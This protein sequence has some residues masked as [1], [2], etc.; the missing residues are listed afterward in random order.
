[1]FGRKQSA[2]ILKNR[3]SKN[4]GSDEPG[5]QGLI[6]G[7]APQGLVDLG[8]QP[9]VPEPPQARRPDPASYMTERNSALMEA[10]SVPPQQ[11]KQARVPVAPPTPTPAPAATPAAEPTPA[12]VA[13]KGRA[14]TR[15][16][17]ADT[18]DV[19]PKPDAIADQKPQQV[20]SPATFQAA[21]W[22]VIVDGPGRGHSMPLRTGVSQLGRD[23]SQSI[24]LDFG[25]NSISRENHASIAFDI[26]QRAFFIGHGGK[27]NL[28]RLNDAPV[29]TTEQLRHGDKIR[30][31]E[32]TLQLIAF[33]GEHFTWSDP[34]EVVAKTPAP[35]TAPA[36]EVA[37]LQLKVAPATQD[38]RPAQGQTPGPVPVKP[39][40]IAEPS[41]NSAPVNADEMEFRKIAGKPL[42]D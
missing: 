34:S 22:L 29:L 8:Q 26:E 21:G 12:P 31:G 39:A 32:T 27:A 11:P 14:K 6:A 18:N 2:F 10:N 41:G 9:V 4:S 5:A 35:M 33:C 37:P 3:K 25:D 28:V 17:G 38:V 13:R 24:Q 7:G 15:L 36:A 1:M 30:I 40:L 19:Q 20:A 16:L 23:D 42:S